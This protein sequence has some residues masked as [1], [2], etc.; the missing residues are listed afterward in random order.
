MDENTNMTTIQDVL[1]DIEAGETMQP[2]GVAQIR[3]AMDTLTKYKSGKKALENRLVACEQWW[4]LQHWQEMSPSGNPYDPQ[5]RS[6][7]LFNVIMGKHADAV[8]AF[9][10]PAIRPREPDDRSEAAM[11]TSIVPVILEQNDF[12][13]T[14]S[15][16]CWTKMKQGTL[17]WGV[18]WDSSKLN[19]LGDVSIREIDLL[20]LF[21]EP[22]VTDIQKSKNLFY[23]ELVDNDVLKQ[24]YPQVGDTLRSDNT[25]VSKY[26]TD[27]Q[28]DTTD[29]SL[30]VDWYY[31]K[32]ENGKSVLHFCKF[33]GE[34]VL[35][36]TEND[37]NMQSGLYEDG[38][39]PFV[40]DA[41]FPVKGS[42][43]GYGYIDIGKSAQEQIDLLN[44]AILKNSV[45]ASTPRW[46]IRSDG[47]INEKEY[48]DWRKPFVHADG[49]LGQDSVM[50]ITVSPL[51][52]N[53]INVIQNKIEELKW[54]TG[55]TD[56]NNGSV[57]SGVT[58][59]SAIAA[60][61]E[62]SGRSSKDATRSAYRAYARL[63]R[64][65]IERIRQFY[66]LP[67]KFRI[68]GQLGTEEYVTYSNQNL[69]QQE[70]LGLGGD[71][72]WRKPVFD[73]EVSAQ[74]SSEYTR[75]SQ[76][77]L[78]LQF[79]QLGFFDPTR[80]D[81]ALAT[82]DMM[83][84]DGKDEISQKIAQNGTLQQELASWQQMALAL[85]ERFDPAMADG[86]AQQILGA[87]AQAQAPAA[88]N[89]KA[90]MPGEEAGTE[91]KTVTDARE[92]SQKSTQP[93]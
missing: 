8:A 31:K 90:E 33:V 50:P 7:W 72:T 69:K 82:L 85:A 26:E 40:I 24:R 89:A 34:T 49:N 42:I 27:D 13:E 83:D 12:E 65:V 60:L 25:F 5:W 81:Q 9:P 76:N 71:V 62:A 80:A 35:S 91:A 28:V 68:R 61:Q 14:Y 64:M 3:T 58:A 18:F 32:I 84:F 59:A 36:A 53:Y 37:P 43:A 15:D 88:G 10:E 11:L 20:N 1:G 16:S 67:R 92:Q 22:G 6:A 52:A 77:E 93:D 19:G 23:A 56:V 46:F 38:D 39:Y 87:D 48:A 4:K 44:Q 2:I 79:Y 66:D 78:A 74:K 63:I 54:T 41:L 29:K 55:N 17:A 51:S 70:L 57:S 21:W 45:M 47:S 30:V 73:I 86:L 75:L